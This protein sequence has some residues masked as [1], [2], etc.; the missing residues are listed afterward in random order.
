MTKTE[1]LVEIGILKGLIYKKEDFII[2]HFM[3]VSKKNDDINFVALGE[4]TNPQPG[5]AY[6]LHGSWITNER[7]GKQFKFKF[8]EVMQ[9]KNTQGIYN[10][11]VRVCKYVGPTV[12]QRLVDAYKEDTIDILKKDPGRVAKEIKGLSPERTFEIQEALKQNEKIESVLIELEKIFSEI[13]G[14]RKSLPMDLVKMFGANAV[15]KI[16]ENPYLVSRI[17]GVGFP[18]ADKIAL[19]IGFD[20]RSPFREK[21]ALFHVLESNMREN[22]GT[23]ASIESA[24]TEIK[25]LTGLSG[26]DAILHGVNKNEIDMT[27]DDYLAINDIATDEQ[28]IAE[29]IVDLLNVKG[30]AAA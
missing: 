26:Y 10:Y 6:R 11:L 22:G 9:P 13:T 25:R 7:F 30:R 17:R 5:L 24:C 12:A 18:T 1:T 8:H 14:V 19:A 4:I 23:Y 28:K 2:A 15:E 20:E 27:A 21:S 16:K 29:K 3:R